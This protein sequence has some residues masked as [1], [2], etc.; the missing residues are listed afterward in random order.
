MRLG[1]HPG[2]WIGTASLWIAGGTAM[3]S[4]SASQVWLFRVGELAIVMGTLLLIWGIK[5]NGKHWWDRSWRF[6]LPWGGPKQDFASGLYVGELRLA[7]NRLDECYLELSIRGF[8]GT[9]ERIDVV[10]VLGNILL[11]RPD[12][13]AIPLPPAVL[14]SDRTQTKAIEPRAE[15][16]LVVQ[17]F[18]SPQVAETVKELIEGGGA[19]FTLTHFRVDMAATNNPKRRASLPFWGGIRVTRDYWARSDRIIHAVATAVAAG[20]ASLGR[21]DD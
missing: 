5:W 16:F 11:E 12:A 14:L 21:S 7:A 19:S 18:L 4:A 20:R 1:L 17:Q 2:V 6:R 8:N 9:G 10:E 3:T 13:E 15:I